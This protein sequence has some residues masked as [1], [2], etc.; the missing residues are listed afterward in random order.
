MSEATAS[1]LRAVGTRRD[2]YPAR[3]ERA[4]QDATAARLD[5]APTVI[6]TFAGGGG[7]SL[8]YAMAGYREL[9]ASDWEEH[10]EEC[11]RVNFP[12]V[13]FWRGD[14]AKLSAAEVFERSGLAP[15][16]LSVF[17]GSPPCQ[18]FSTAGKREM[19]DPRNTLFME[20]VRLLRALQP[21]AMV[22]E[23]VSGMVKGKMKLVFAQILRELKSSGY[24]VKAWKLNAQWL[25]VPQARERMIFIGARED[26]GIVPT[27]PPAESM[28]ISAREAIEDIDQEGDPD[29]AW[30]LEQ[31]AKRPKRLTEWA[32]IPPGRNLAWVRKQRGGDPNQGFAALKYDPDRPA[33][34]VVKSDSA[35]GLHGA[36]HWGEPRRFTR[37][38]Y[39]RFTSFPDGYQWPGEWKD[40]VAR[41]GNCVPPFMMR[42]VARHVRQTILE[43]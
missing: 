11:F 23:N 43:A 15:G 42:A 16:E 29:R 30:L 8:G 17:D 21:K 24:V 1:D 19:A 12:E 39:S 35:I 37:R 40:A 34:T 10:A 22:M 41:I 32:A 27:H 9:L 18:G 36:M 25:G 6:S 5:S 31:W 3:L 7:S 38:E 2:P 14:I 20:Y 26:L 4:W 13:P 33:P 28:P